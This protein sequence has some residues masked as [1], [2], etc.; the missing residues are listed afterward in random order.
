VFFE[1]ILQLDLVSEDAFALTF[2]AGGVMRRIQ[3]VEKLPKME[4]TVLGFDVPDIKKTM[5][6]LRGRG[7]VFERYGFLEQDADGVWKAPS[8][9]RIA[10]F[11]DPDGNTLSL[12]QF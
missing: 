9:A 2:D 11:K 12:V 10:W 3:K 6:E 7:V 1:K 5:E 8:G 4:H